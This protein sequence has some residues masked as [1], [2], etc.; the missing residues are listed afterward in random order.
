MQ[1]FGQ[2]TT[3]KI[4]KLSPLFIGFGKQALEYAKVF[5]NFGISINSVCVKN[6]KKNQKKFNK[7]KIKNRYN[8]LGKALREK[9]YNL[10]L[11][12]LPWYEIEKKINFIIKNSY[13]RKILCEKP[14]ALSSKKLLD[15]QKTSRKFNK[16]IY[17][18]Y[19]RRHYETYKTIKNYIKNNNFK[20]HAYIPEKINK[21]LKKVDR[22]IYGFIKYQLTSHWLDFFLS[23]VIFYFF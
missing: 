13:N 15:I 23:L 6:L 16:K 22:N 11:I 3:K 9:K 1:N 5:K 10:I 4:Y 17:I 21:T 20:M 7:F 14:V 12:F 18:L 8:N 19:N 2:N